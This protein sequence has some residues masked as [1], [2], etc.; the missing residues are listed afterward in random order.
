MSLLVGLVALLLVSR[1]IGLVGK[2]YIGE[3]V[4]ITNRE[5]EMAFLETFDSRILTVGPD[6]GCI[7]ESQ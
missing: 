1:L 6:M 4:S 5:M 3:L 7:S 2:S